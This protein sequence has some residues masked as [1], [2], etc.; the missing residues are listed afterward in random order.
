[1]KSQPESNSLKSDPLGSLKFRP[2]DPPNTNILLYKPG[3]QIDTQIS[4]PQ[5]PGSPKVIILATWLGGASASRIAVYCRGYQAAYP[6]AS[7][8]LLRT[9]LSDIT[10]KSSAVVQAQLKPAHDFLLSAFPPNRSHTHDK[11]V[12]HMFSHGG[13]NTALQLSRLLREGAFSAA[14]PIPL[15]GVILD[16]C[17]GSSSFI[18]AYSGAVYSLPQSRIIGAN[19]LG[20][21]CL[22]PII[23]TISMLQSCGLL[24]SVEDLRRE[25]ND[26]NS[27][28]AVPRLY[29]H[30]KGDRLVAAEDVASHAAE[31][32]TVLLVSRETWDFAEHVA[33]P[34]EDAQRYWTAVRRFVD[35]PQHARDAKI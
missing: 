27:F 4:S 13:C 18:K 28:G 2:I 25:L 30:S 17:P 34:L 19:L 7:I 10:V 20:R 6:T 24:S 22:V 31:I 29:L 15:I 3:S 32:G 1:M 33:L 11:A 9:V 14:F 8:L 26:F 5:C 12:L 23:G 21:A 16:S 35:G